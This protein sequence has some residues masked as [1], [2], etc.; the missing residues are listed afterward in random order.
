MARV[1]TVKKAQKDYPNA[2][3]K[4]GDQ[5][6]WWKFR[7]GGKHMSKVY[8][9]PS[10]LTGS[11]FLS[12]IYG[13]L[14]SIENLKADASA[15][16]IAADLRQASEEIQEQADETERNFSNMPYGLQQGDTGQMM[17]QRVSDAGE[18]ASSFESLADEADGLKDEE[19]ED[20][21]SDEDYAERIDA[22]KQRIIDEAQA[23]SYDGE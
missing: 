7:Y 9:K 3:I 5:Y 19:K 8:P 2:G 20:G 11:S 16:D 1:T 15:E 4:K 6:Y 18:L 23:L 13:A 14:E 17:E 10:Q 12:S 22:E 21:E